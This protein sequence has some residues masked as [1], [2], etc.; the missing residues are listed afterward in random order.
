M[1]ALRAIC[2]WPGLPS[3]W[4]LG[5]A[6]GLAVAIV[7]AWCLCGLLLAT[8]IWPAWISVGVL[9]LLWLMALVTWLVAIVRNFLRITSLL[10]ASSSQAAEAFVAAQGE[11]LAGNFFESEALLLEI[12]H[13]HPRDAEALLLL[14]SVLRR[15]KRWPAALRRLGQLD[16]MD[17]SY[18]WQYE[19]KREKCLIERDMAEELAEQSQPPR[20]SIDA[21]SRESCHASKVSNQDTTNKS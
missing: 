19:M 12:L 21:D 10:E 20:E 3:A 16:L 6:R 15:T 14:V 18:R 2:L 1:L 7:F 4:F 17:T 13:Q 5:V 9:R 11:Y 8:F